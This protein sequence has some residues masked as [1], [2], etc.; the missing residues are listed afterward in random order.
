MGRN[1]NLNKILKRS[2]WTLSYIDA[3]CYHI[4]LIAVI[5]IDH[6]QTLLIP[7]MPNNTRDYWYRKCKA[8][9]I[10]ESHNKSSLKLLAT[11]VCYYFQIAGFF[12]FSEAEFCLI[13]NIE[14]HLF[15]M[16]EIL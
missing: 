1:R 7:I 15:W 16:I 6:F 9:P 5:K 12:Y 3:K 4:I 10:A 13:F 14:N 2:I 8:G 11:R